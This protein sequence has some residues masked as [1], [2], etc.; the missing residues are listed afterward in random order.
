ME[1]PNSEHR[2]HV[3]CQSC[4]V[5]VVIGKLLPLFNRLCKTC[6]TILHVKGKSE[7]GER[8][9]SACQEEQRVTC[10]TLGRSNLSSVKANSVYLNS[11][12]ASCH[13]N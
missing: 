2:W 3:N 12:I 5:G 4:H 8:R 10:M 13:I 9:F 1:S 7:A 6:P 11:G